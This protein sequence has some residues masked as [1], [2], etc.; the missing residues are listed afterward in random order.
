[1]SK[2]MPMGISPTFNLYH[3]WS[4]L[5]GEQRWVGQARNWQD[6]DSLRPHVRQTPAAATNTH[7][8]F[9]SSVGAHTTYR[10]IEAMQDESGLFIPPTN[11][12]TYSL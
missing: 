5:A 1:M 10:I 7:N 9:T 6:S 3:V 8:V 4:E 2:N 11:T 12:L